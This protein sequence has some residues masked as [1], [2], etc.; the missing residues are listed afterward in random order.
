M[1]PCTPCPAQSNASS[2]PPLSPLMAAADRVDS[3]G[4]P[5]I[6]A[7]ATFFPQAA[8][9]S[10]CS[11][12]H[13]PPVDVRCGC[14]GFP[15]GPSDSARA[16]A[17][18]EAERFPIRRVRASSPPLAATQHRT[19]GYQDWNRDGENRT[20]PRAAKRAKGYHGRM[21]S[22]G[23]ISIA[24]AAG[25]DFG[26]SRRDGSGDRATAGGSAKRPMGAGTDCPRSQRST[27][28]NNGRMNA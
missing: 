4:T 21:K 16:S 17:P 12:H 26:N 11:P 13:I 27:L 8:T 14:R 28:R 10:F 22:I 19:A 24:P 2:T 23:E 6:T 25:R 9:R 18:G 15:S 3:S 1:R 7:L 20:A 5:L